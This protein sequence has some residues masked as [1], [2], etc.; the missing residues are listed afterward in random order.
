MDYPERLVCGLIVI[1]IA[2]PLSASEV[3]QREDYAFSFPISGGIAAEF[4]AAPVSLAVYR[5]VTDPELR[6]MGVYNAAGEA[7]PRIIESPAVK[8]PEAEQEI[9]LG[10]VPLHGPVAEQGEQLRLLMQQDASGTRFSLDTRGLDKEAAGTASGKPA[11]A[12]AA[13]IVDLRAVE[14]SPEALRFLWDKST[15]GFMGTVGVET[16]TNLQDW[17]ELAQGTLADLSWENTRI[18]QDRIELISPPGDFLR[19]TWSG[20]PADWSLQ[21]LV[22]LRRGDGPEETRDWLELTPSAVDTQKREFTFDSGAFAPVDRINFL[23]PDDNVVLRARI[24]YRG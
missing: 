12:D 1:T 3:P 9:P 14:K 16:S 2:W 17:Y 21:T 24:L 23:L 19:I 4:R 5:S 20:L 15:S 11:P 13:Y 22:G 7:V 6:D 8:P 18:D 10:L